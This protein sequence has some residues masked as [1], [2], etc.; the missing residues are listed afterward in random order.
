V[1]K[2]MYVEAL[3]YY[4]EHRG[5][6]WAWA[7]LDSAS[8]KAPK[9]GLLRGPIQPIAQSLERNDTLSPTDVAF[10]SR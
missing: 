3:L 1:F 7:S 6:D 2:M 8:V 10:R 5:I 9:G 4:D